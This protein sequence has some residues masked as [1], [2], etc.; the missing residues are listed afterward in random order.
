MQGT[1]TVMVD[2]KVLDQKE[3]PYFQPGVLKSYINGIAGVATS[4]APSPTASS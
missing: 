1:P 4:T 3:V 2:R